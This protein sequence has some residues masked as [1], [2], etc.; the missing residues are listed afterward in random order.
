MNLVDLSD[1]L[2]PDLLCSLQLSLQHFVLGFDTLSHEHSLSGGLQLGS[3]RL[4]L[5]IVMGQT[6]ISLDN[7]GLSYHSL[8]GCPSDLGS[9]H[10]GFLLGQ[11][12]GWAHIWT[13]HIVIELQFFWTFLNLL[14]F[15]C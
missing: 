8:S 3:Q 1:L 10:T 2:N 13:S 4:N 15:A 14:H 9:G 7:V 12:L 5:N 11:L 6:I